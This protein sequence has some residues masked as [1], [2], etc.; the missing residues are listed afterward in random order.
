[1]TSSLANADT[2][3]A[4]RCSRDRWS[5][6]WNIDIEHFRGYVF[7]WTIQMMHQSGLCVHNLICQERFVTKALCIRIPAPHAIRKHASQSS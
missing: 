5:T 7:S 6:A 2:G 3:S 4:I 1:M